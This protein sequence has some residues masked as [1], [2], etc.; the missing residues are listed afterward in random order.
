MGGSSH[1]R[2]RDSLRSIL[3]RNVKRLSTRHRVQC[4]RQ[5]LVAR[6]DVPGDAGGVSEYTVPLLAVPPKYVVPWRTL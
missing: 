3:R 4:E 1:K 5:R 6:R 2:T